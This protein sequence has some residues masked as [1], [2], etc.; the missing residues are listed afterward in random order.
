M[1]PELWVGLLLCLAGIIF[2]LMPAGGKETPQLG[3]SPDK[4][5][6]TD[7]TQVT[8]GMNVMK[9]ARPREV[10]ERKAYF[11][12]D[13]LEHGAR[14]AEFLRRS[15]AMREALVARQ[16]LRDQVVSLRAQE[17]GVNHPNVLV[18]SEKRKALEKEII[19]KWTEFQEQDRGHRGERKRR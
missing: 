16:D 5:S 17:L 2:Q 15:P 14:S 19:A 6:G 1:R 11:D 10:S 13:R 12:F 18:F 4:W 9:S 8:G 3:V 7:R